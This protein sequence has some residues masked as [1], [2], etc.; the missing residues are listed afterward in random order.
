MDAEDI[1]ELLTRF[2]IFL[3]LMPRKLDGAVKV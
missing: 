1:S 3:K 2:R